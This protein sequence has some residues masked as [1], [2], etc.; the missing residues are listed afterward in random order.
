[1]REGVALARETIDSGAAMA[2]LDEL[3]AFSQAK[4]AV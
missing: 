1:L 3:V 4:V 2:R